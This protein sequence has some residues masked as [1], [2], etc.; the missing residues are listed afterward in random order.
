MSEP[1]LN[2]EEVSALLQ[3]VAPQETASALLAALPPLHQPEK[4]DS[5]GFGE[6]QIAGPEN[7]P[8]FSSLHEQPLAQLIID[9][10]QHDFRRDI[11]A[12]FKDMTEQSY[13]DILDSDIPRLY[14][15]L[16]VSGL[17]SMLAVLDTGLALA[18]V[19]A[20]LGGSGD[21]SGREDLTLTLV[22]TKLAE[23][24]AESIG[25]ILTRLWRPVREISFSLGRMDA[26]PMALA[27][28][29][30]DITCFSVSQVIVLG[31]DIRGELSVHY[32]VPFLEPMLEAMRSQEKTAKKLVDKQWVTELKAAVDHVPFQLKLEM[33]HCHTHV[34]DF[35]YIK[36][37]D[38]LPLTVAE[39]D[40][41]ILWIEG[42]PA[43]HVRP[44]GQHG[45]LAAEIL[46]P[47]TTGDMT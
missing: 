9:R 45:M 20:L 46:D 27:M 6:N 42:L 34:R 26:D 47:I 22:E 14:F 15:T 25:N 33:G 21:I 35:M 16:E 24:V 29:A 3:T 11:P 17:G 23:R 37:G 43:F 39:N 1:V 31:E 36:P 8:M 41:A 13:L 28:T 12:F 30:E 18:Y 10:W 5:F 2:P 38:M 44:G 4:V 40:P 7:Y 32:P 19:D